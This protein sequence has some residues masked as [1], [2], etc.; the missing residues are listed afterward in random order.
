MGDVGL[1][2]AVEAVCER[3][4]GMAVEQDRGAAMTHDERL[5]V[6]IGEVALGHRFAPGS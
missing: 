5:T 2:R 1:A 6:D 4:V 3:E